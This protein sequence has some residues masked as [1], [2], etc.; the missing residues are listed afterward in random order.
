MLKR[1]ILWDRDIPVNHHKPG[2]ADN[3]GSSR[4][5]DYV[6]PMKCAQCPI[7]GQECLAE[8]DER[9]AFFC[10]WAEKGNSVHIA[11]I[12]YRNGVVAEQPAPSQMESESAIPLGFFA[13]R[14]ACPHF[15]RCPTR[16]GTDRCDRN[17]GRGGV[18]LIKDCLDCL[19]QGGP[20]P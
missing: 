8:S 2:W 1:R 17:K 19:E 15:R 18:V 11:H 10:E 9:F 16:C 13:R 4:G 5:D 7:V 3:T 14:D 12:R 6:Q 20:P